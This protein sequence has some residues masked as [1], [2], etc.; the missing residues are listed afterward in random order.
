MVEI[1]TLMLEIVTY[2]CHGNIH[3]LANGVAE[4]GNHQWPLAE[5]SSS[6]SQGFNSAALFSTPAFLANLSGRYGYGTVQQ[7]DCG[8]LPFA[9]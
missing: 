3:W 8:R 4:I 5:E 6:I 7:H 1:T 9:C 2:K